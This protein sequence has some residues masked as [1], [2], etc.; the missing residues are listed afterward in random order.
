MMYYRKRKIDMLL[1]SHML[2][3]VSSNSGVESLRRHVLLQ[4]GVHS[5]ALHW[6]ALIKGGGLAQLTGLV[7]LTPK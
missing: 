3:T 4:L 5:P 2:C 7:R 1:M 6:L